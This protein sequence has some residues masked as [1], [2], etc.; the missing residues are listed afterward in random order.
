MKEQF[1]QWY[2]GRVAANLNIRSSDSCVL[3]CVSFLQG[4]KRDLSHCRHHAWLEAGWIIIYLQLTKNV[5][6]GPVV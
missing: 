6:V 4:S 5:A 1:T 3:D 2:V